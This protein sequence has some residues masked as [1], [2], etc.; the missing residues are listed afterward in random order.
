VRIAGYK[1]LFVETGTR[2]PHGVALVS[3][4][5][6]HTWTRGPNQATYPPSP[7]NLWGFN[8]YHDAWRA[9]WSGQVYGTVIVGV[10]GFGAVELYRRGWRAEKAEIVAVH[11][12]RGLAG[13]RLDAIDRGPGAERL[14]L[15]Y[16]VPVL[17]SLR[18]L[19][20]ETERWGVPGRRLLGSE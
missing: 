19:R 12:P 20:R 1:W 5:D 10:T 9:R 3:G 14:R 16:D 6:A 8:A 13:R 11:L 15:A 4:Y 18:A 2:W 7:D 17:R